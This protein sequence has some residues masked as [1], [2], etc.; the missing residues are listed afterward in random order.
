M[1]FRGALLIILF[2]TPSWAIDKACEDLF[3]SQKVSAQSLKCLQSCVTLKIDFSTFMCSQQCE[4]YCKNKCKEILKSIEDRL[5]TG[6]PKDWPLK[7]KIKKWKEL[8][9]RQ[10]A[11]SIS[12]MPEELIRG[13][14]IEIY[15]LEK[16]I[17]FPNPSTN[18]NSRPF[19]VSVYDSAFD[20]KYDIAQIL[21]HELAH[22]LYQQMSQDMKSSYNLKMNWVLID[23]ARELWISR[24]DG[25]VEE[26]GKI[27]P[28][29]DFSNNV[30]Y[31]LWKPE[32]LKSVSPHAFD[33]L[34]THFPNMKIQEGCRYAQ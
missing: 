4:E 21:S 9:R 30:E 5:R 34:K 22:A 24:K 6:F 25:F 15:R 8:E 20:K 28:E 12:K 2:A 16:S 13:N 32:K 18:M 26:D 29:E 23:R 17:I 27:S 31:Y 33:W 14:S 1:I 7:E 10:T 11:E 3:F 19:K